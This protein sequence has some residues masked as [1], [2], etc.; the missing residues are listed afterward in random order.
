[1]ELSSDNY[2]FNRQDSPLVSV[3]IP[4]H[5][6]VHF[7]A[8][9]INSVLGQTYQNFEI[10]VVDD[11]STDHTRELVS[12]YTQVRYFYQT[13]R[14]LSASRNAGFRYSKGNF[15]VFLDSD[16][17]LVPTALATG[18]HYLT[19]HPECALVAGRSQDITAGGARL[20]SFSPFVLDNKDPY[21]LLL[22]WNQIWGP[23]SVMYRRE[24]LDS[25]SSLG[26][27][28]VSL[29]PAADY[30]LYLR[31]A[32]KYPIWC[33]NEVVLEYRR[34]SLS[35]SNNL[36]SMYRDVLAVLRAQSNYVRTHPQYKQLYKETIK[37]HRN[38]YC[39]QVL[40]HL[41]TY[42]YLNLKDNLQDAF[43]L[44]KY[45]PFPFFGRIA[46]KIS[47]SVLQIFGLRG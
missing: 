2:S 29:S 19:L 44:L 34:H 9:A 7:L 11:G 43:F 30:D 25:F 20:Q 1:M 21:H 41:A 22:G 16:D 26:P 5:N 46:G 8:E 4:T 39:S 47:R 12:E 17:R 23:A 42:R 24:H 28:N 32:Q 3:V 35:M 36:R 33:H 45:Y 37:R 6:Y 10:V 27:F 18:V 14:G 15:L 13:N 40:E 31:I 38:Y